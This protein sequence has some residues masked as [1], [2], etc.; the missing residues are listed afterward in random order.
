M[1][2]DAEAYVK[3]GFTVLKIKVGIDD[4]TEDI[5]RVADESVFSPQ[6]A[7]RILNRRAAD[8][9]NIKLMKAG[10]IH[11]AITINRLA[12]ACGVEC[13]ARSMIETRIDITAAAHFAAAMLNV[14]RLDFDSPLMMSNDPV[15]GGI[16]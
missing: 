6:D 14:T 2:E 5:A 16:R 10:G 11:K 9:I 13:M 7:F 4:I 15:I 1:G 12:E 3:S 8:L